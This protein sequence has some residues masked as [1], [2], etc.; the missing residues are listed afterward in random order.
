MEIML[1]N[2]KR[3]EVAFALLKKSGLCS[4]EQEVLVT[5]LRGFSWVGDPDAFCVF[6][7]DNRLEPWLKEISDEFIV[8]CK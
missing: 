5:I 1:K 4:E 6:N 7:M 3:E 8:K 2:K